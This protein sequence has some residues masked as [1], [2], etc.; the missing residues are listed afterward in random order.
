[1]TFCEVR[2]RSCHADDAPGSAAAASAAA[3]AA[4]SATA[5]TATA[6]VA[7]ANAHQ[8]GGVPNLSAPAAVAV[9]DEAAAR[10][11]EL[12]NHPPVRGWPSDTQLRGLHSA[13]PAP[14]TFHRSFSDSLKSAASWRFAVLLDVCGPPSSTGSPKSAGSRCPWRSGLATPASRRPARP[15]SAS[16]PF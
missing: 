3:T 16:A 9:A 11:E 2:L 12:A 10:L 15:R 7:D 1:M 4:S 5:M 6:V 14:L 13:T 8:F